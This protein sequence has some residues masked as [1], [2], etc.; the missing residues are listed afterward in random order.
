MSTYD[1]LKSVL[2]KR[3][4]GFLCLLDPDRM[5]KQDLVHTAVTCADNGADALL[6][7]GSFLLYSDFDRAVRE[8]R[9]AVGLPLLIFPGPDMNQVSSAA[10][11]ILF[12]CMISGR[13]PDLLIGQQVKAAPIVKAY[14][15]EAI[16]TGYMLVDSGRQTTAEYISNT[17][18]MPGDKPE[19][20]TAHAL[21]AQFLGMQC[22]YLD[23]GSG[24]GRMVSDEMIAAVA[25]N[26]SIPVIAGGG[27]REP[28]DA[29]AKAAAGADFVVVGSVLE[30]KRDPAL[31][32]DFA[33][34]VHSG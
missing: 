12:L 21:A 31:V 23:A 9:R 2:G 8:V 34:A 27:I 32:R 14:G 26:V 30:A 10:D 6:M 17:K 25:G 29:G 24:A 1:H 13:N 11:A 18:P 33:D 20:A 3:G 22:V 5:D 4:T 28:R 15:L 7:G 16:S 19:I